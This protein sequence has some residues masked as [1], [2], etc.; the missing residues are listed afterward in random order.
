MKRYIRSFYAASSD[1]RRPLIEALVSVVG[2]GFNGNRSDFQYSD[3]YQCNVAY[4]IVT[5]SG[6]GRTYTLNIYTEDTT[7]RISARIIQDIKRFID[8]NY[9]NILCNSYPE[10]GVLSVSGY[11]PETVETIS[12]DIYMRFYETNTT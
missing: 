10:I 6:A 11:V 2:I 1:P 9:S 5:E 7:K 3:N 4:K 12:N 8:R